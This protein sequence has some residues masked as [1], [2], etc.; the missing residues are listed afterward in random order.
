MM[1]TPFVGLGTALLL[2]GPGAAAEKTAPGASVPPPRRVRVPRL[3]GEITLDGR[4]DEPVWRA[5]ARVRLELNDGSGAVR[6]ATT[7]R[8]WYDRDALHLGWTCRDTDIQATLTAR[9]SRFWEEE[10]A[11]FF[12]TPGALSDYYELQWNPLGGVFDAR[13]HN[14][15]DAATGLSRKF[16]GDWSFTA[17]GMRHAVRVEG[18]VGDATDTDRGWQAEVRLPFA[19]LGVPAPRPGAVWR[20]NFYRFNRGGGQPAELQAWSPTRRPSFHEPGRFGFLE[21]GPPAAVPAH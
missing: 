21:F 18:T 5:A 17:A 6:D 13:I 8:L 2:A 14:E 15:L 10:V 20:G 12:L 7:V 11:E 3:T 19:D 4:L 1:K 9:D 16:T